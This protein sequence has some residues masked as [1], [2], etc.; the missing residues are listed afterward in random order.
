LKTHVEHRYQTAQGPYQFW[1]LVGALGAFALHNDQA[2]D[3]LCALLDEPPAPEPGNAGWRAKRRASMLQCA[4]AE[5]LGHLGPRAK[6]AV[7]ALG[8]MLRRRGEYWLEEDRKTAARVLGMIGPDAL[9]TLRAA[10][11][12][13]VNEA[14]I[15]LSGLG[16][17]ARPSLDDLLR[18]LQTP[19]G[20][21]Q[22][23]RILTMLP[24]YGAEANRAVPVLLDKIRRSRTITHTCLETLSEIGP[25]A[26][27]RGV[28]A[29]A[30]RLE[31]LQQS[32]SRDEL[33]TPRAFG[34]LR[35]FGVDAR[36]LVPWLIR[37]TANAADPLRSNAM[38]LLADIA[39][40]DQQSRE[41]I[42]A[43]LQRPQPNDEYRSEAERALRKIRTAASLKNQPKLAD[44]DAGA[45]GAAPPKVADWIE[46]LNG[47]HELAIHELGKL[48]PAAKAAVPALVRG[49][50]NR[51]ESNLL[52]RVVE[53]LVQIAPENEELRRS[54]PL[55]ERSPSYAVRSAA[56]K[57]KKAIAASEAVPAKK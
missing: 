57:A 41:E 28:E 55:L 12:A 26:K 10:Q 35:E 56:A 31:E 43:I 21:E 32:G 37:Q 40:A 36:P 1:S 46:R 54:L 17:N 39:I 3:Y 29:V 20:W 18:Q 53:T 13:G 4:V 22:E 11:E 50:Q 52:A 6:K 23:L 24:K 49:L 27:R 19:M 33:I 38:R 44:D 16:D 34:T 25:E 45:K 7:P 47:E 8:R 5:E 15:G 48:G 9:E 30:L 2:L 42:A 14:L 51:Y